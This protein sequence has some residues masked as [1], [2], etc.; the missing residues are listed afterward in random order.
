MDDFFLL[1]LVAYV[2]HI[3][4]QNTT[5][6]GELNAGK[7]NNVSQCSNIPKQN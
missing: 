7:Q 6:T 3:C 4:T 2:Q 5:K 1:D